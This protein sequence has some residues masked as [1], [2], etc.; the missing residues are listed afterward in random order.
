MTAADL[1]PLWLSLRVALVATA[2]IVGIGTPLAYMLARARFPGKG[3]LSGLLVLPLVL[4]PTVLGYALLLLLG[5]RTWLGSVLEQTLGIVVVF[6]WTG[7]VVA[8]TVTAFPLFLLPAR[9]AIEGVDAALEDAA[10]LLGRGEFSVFMSITLPLAWRGIAAGAV[11]AFVRALGDF[12]ATMMV[13]GNIPGRTRTTALAIYD[14]VEANEH[15][16]AGGLSLCLAVVSIVALWGV[17]RLP[18]IVSGRADC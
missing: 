14:A 9:G 4:P 15:A 7:A 8:S 16:R 11:L 17:Q 3:L 1:E 18:S 10:R 2:L 6:Q 13:A 12:G 5:R